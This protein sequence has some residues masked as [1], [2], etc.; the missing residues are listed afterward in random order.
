VDIGAADLG[1]VRT[2]WQLPDQSAATT[3]RPVNDIETAGPV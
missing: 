3:I 1:S 2:I